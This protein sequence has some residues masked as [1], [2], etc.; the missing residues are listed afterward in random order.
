MGPQPR[1]GQGCVLGGLL[2]AAQTLQSLPGVG[3]AAPALSRGHPACPRPVWVTVSS[4]RVVLL[5]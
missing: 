4:A 2:G 5:E 3:T 1:S